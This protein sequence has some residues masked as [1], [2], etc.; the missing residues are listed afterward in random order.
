M[1]ICNLKSLYTQ[2]CSTNQK[3][4][5]IAVTFAKHQDFAID[6]LIFVAQI[7]T[8]INLYYLWIKVF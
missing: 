7:L 3:Q 4:G 2:S 6:L 8:L 1:E 5:A